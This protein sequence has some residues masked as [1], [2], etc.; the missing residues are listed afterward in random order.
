MI[1]RNIERLTREAAHDLDRAAELLRLAQRRHDEPLIE[2]AWG[3]LYGHQRAALTLP[4]E[5]SVA[6][7]DTAQRACMICDRPLTDPASREHGVGPICRGR[8]NAL[9]ARSIEAD[10]AAASVLANALRPALASC[11]ATVRPLLAAAL[12]QIEAA[13]ASNSP[14]RDWRDVVKVFEL[15]QSFETTT[16]LHAGLEDITLA[17]GYV[18]LV[19][20][21]RDDVVK[22]K[23]ELVFE[24]TCG[25]LRLS[26]PR[27]R[28]EALRTTVERVGGFYF[29]RE[30]TYL[31]PATAHADVR[32]LLDSHW[33]HVRGE[34]DE[35]LQAAASW[36]PPTGWQAPSTWQDM[37]ALATGQTT[38]PQRT[39]REVCRV[40]ACDDGA[41]LVTPYNAPFVQRLKALPRKA[42]RWD[43]NR[44]AWW[45]ADTVLSDAVA[46]I[47]ACFPG[48]HVAF[49]DGT[50]AQAA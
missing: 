2:R 8:S 6:R 9:L 35:G 3:W 34:A 22:G 37:R 10:T 28:S 30:R 16:Q 45:V 29:S 47:R 18:A 32:A 12:S 43:P 46:L 36:T 5:S 44:R 33:L 50:H 26:S 17:L 40:T 24:H 7:D 11:H 42:R 21:W 19:N 48:L 39:Q 27:A 31:F 4:S 23:A 14:R 1:C 20:L 41:H 49:N 25:V 13:H 38:Q 15:V